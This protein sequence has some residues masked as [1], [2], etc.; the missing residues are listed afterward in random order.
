MYSWPVALLSLALPLAAQQTVT[1]SPTSLSFN[2]VAN[3]ATAGA[4]PAPQEISLGLQP[5]NPTQDVFVGD[6]P[7]VDGQT[8]M[9]AV[10]PGGATGKLVSGTRITVSVNPAGLPNGTYRGYVSISVPFGAISNPQI[11]VPVTF[12]VAGVAGNGSP[13]PT[14]LFS[15][16]QLSFQTTVNGT[17]AD[18]YLSIATSVPARIPYTLTA[19]VPWLFV[20]TNSGTTL[21]STFVRVASNGLPPGTHHGL[22][23]LSA[24]GAANNGATVPVSLT[25]TAPAQPPT[26]SPSSLIFT[27]VEG[28]PPPPAQSLILSSVTPLAYSLSASQPWL[29]FSRNDGTTPATVTV[30]INPINY[31]AGTYTANVTI[32][33]ANSPSN[34]PLL[35]PVTLQVTKNLQ[36]LRFSEREV[37]FDYEQG[38]APPAPRTI[39]FTALNGLS[40][41]YTAS[42]NRAWVAVAPRNAI[43]PAPLQ[44]YLE[45]GVLKTLAPGTYLAEITVNVPGAAEPNTIISVALRVSA[46]PVLVTS[47]APIAFSAPFTGGPASTKTR[48][49]VA[50]SGVLGIKATTTSFGVS[51]WANASLDSTVTPAT[52]TVT[53]TPPSGLAAGNYLTHVDIASPAN[54]LTI[55]VWLSVGN[56]PRLDVSR[57]QLA[58]NA[59]NRYAPQ[60]VQLSSSNSNFSFSATPLSNPGNWLSVTTTSNATPA[61]LAVTVNPASLTEA[62]FYGSIVVLALGADNPST[63]IPVTVTISADTLLRT[64]PT[65]LLFTQVQGAM[66]PA[67]QTIQVTSGQPVLFRSSVTAGTPDGVNWLVLSQPST[68]TNGLPLEVSLSRAAATL[69]LGRYVAIITIAGPD[70]PN[71][72]QFA[73]SLFVTGPP[74][75]ITT[76]TGIANSATYQPSALSPGMLVTIVGTNLGPARGVAG[77]LVGGRFTTSGAGVRVLF[78]GIVA[79]ILYASSTQINA[80]VPYA[81][82]GLSS[83]QLSVQY[84]NQT[85]P[86]VSTPLA[87]A[88][89]GIFTVDGRQVAA[90]NQDGT[91]NSPANPASAGSV[92]VLYL[93]GEGLT[94]PAGIDGEIVAATNLRQPVG[95]VRVRVNGVELPPSDILYAGSAP[96]LVAG[97]MQ[98][99]FRLPPGAPSNDATPVDVSIGESQSP[100]RTTVAVR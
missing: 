16:N 71:P 66:P 96:Q 98:V 46:G 26:T 23:T 59:A 94:T 74:P 67:A 22:I 47:T 80:I 10:L 13:N 51:G 78:N 81:L 50:S 100:P 82:A 6:R 20:L 8:W 63:V 32:L 87:S 57:P 91:V 49:I 35:V 27:M 95:R 12:T 31:S 56:T 40:L 5:A 15:P 58:F 90:L 41:A 14:I 69:P 28:A 79:P 45:Y 38:Q 36:S 61:T 64:V 68:Q 62:T 89:P 97:L 54:T 1:Y 37:V 88:A 86:A 84:Q 65:D 93:T 11:H 39:A 21:N 53:V 92:V 73:V 72:I 18:Q 76:V 24:P 60:T 2:Y 30:G 17:P 75:P 83:A 77:D 33:F 44:L 4:T 29:V 3:G 9:S 7:D 99:N 70:S 25:I 19:N 42:S 48:L 85:S 55:P 34:Y 52:L 43:T